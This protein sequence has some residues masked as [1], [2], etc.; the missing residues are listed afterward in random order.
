MVAFDNAVVGGGDGDGLGVECCHVGGEGDVGD[1]IDFGTGIETYRH[2]FGGNRCQSDVVGSSSAAFGSINA[3]G[4][5]EAVW[6]WVGAGDG[7]AEEVVLVEVGA[8]GDGGWGWVGSVSVVGGVAARECD[9][10]KGNGRLGSGHPLVVAVGIGGGLHGEDG[11][12]ETPC[13]A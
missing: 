3:G 4:V 5:D 12:A 13:S 1:G 6:R 2:G 7:V 8:G 10:R 9:I 11:A